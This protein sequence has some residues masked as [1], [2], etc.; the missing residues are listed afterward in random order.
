VHLRLQLGALGRPLN[1]AFRG[2]G[3]SFVLIYETTDSKF[4][5]RAVSALEA[6]G[7]A[8]YKIGTGYS[9]N[10]HGP[11][12]PTENQI[13]IYIEQETDA[14]RANEI[15]LELGAVP[16]EPLGVVLERYKAL[17]VIAAL[18]ALALG[19]LIAANWNSP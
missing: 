18:V 11:M 10:F 5:A 9:E 15:L 4:A 16:E 19:V 17:V 2:Q 13:C 12:L 6:A 14:G 8:A 7:I 3:N 1:S